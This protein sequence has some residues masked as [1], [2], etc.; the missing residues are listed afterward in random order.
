M[1]EQTR[2][3]K[4]QVDALLEDRKIKAEEAEAQRQRDQD[5]I[6][7]L[8]DKLVLQFMQFMMSVFLVIYH[9]DLQLFV[10]QTSR[11]LSSV[12]DIKFPLNFQIYFYLSPLTCQTPANSEPVA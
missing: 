10:K 9:C 7:A 12:A 2:L 5:R 1:E 3:A 11:L 4:E 6:A 8:T